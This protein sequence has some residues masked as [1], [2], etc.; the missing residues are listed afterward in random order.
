MKVA[1]LK[2]NAGNIQSVTYALNRLG[3]DP[4]LT[5]DP[6]EIRSADKV[7]FPG[8]GEAASAMKSLQETGLD[9]IIPQLKQPVIGICVGL[10]LMCLHS[11]EG[12]TQGMGIFDVKV[13]K[14]PTKEGFKVPQMGWNTINQLKSKLFAG[15]I[16]DAYVYYVHSFYAEIG[17][18][19]AAVTDYVLP[20]SAALQRDNFYAVQFHTEKS[21]TVG[22]EILRNFLDLKV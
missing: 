8:V 16:P 2:Y 3:I 5:N 21:S 15:I 11:E 18:N 13:K 6:E 14:F 17:K 20:Y 1:L 22:A 9:I 19:T 10:Q 4:L 12:N 7:I